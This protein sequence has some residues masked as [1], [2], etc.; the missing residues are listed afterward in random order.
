[1]NH[2]AN[3]CGQFTIH[4]LVESLAAQPCGFVY[5][6]RRKGWTCADELVRFESDPTKYG[7]PIAAELRSRSKFC[8]SCAARDGL[9]RAGFK[10]PQRRAGRKA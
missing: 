7:N 2:H 6:S 10:V 5:G 9:Q 8:W 4:E 3:V 1:M